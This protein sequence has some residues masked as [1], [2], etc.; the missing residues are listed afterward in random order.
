M[1]YSIRI[2]EWQRKLLVEAIQNTPLGAMPKIAESDNFG[3]CPPDA[4][5]QEAWTL[6]QMLEGLPALEA[7]S[8]GIL[9][10]LCE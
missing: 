10:L 3:P 1:A 8:P 7:E 4:E 2:N 5:A 9:N 6:V